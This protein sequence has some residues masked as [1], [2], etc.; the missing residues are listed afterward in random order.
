ML[1]LGIVSW[2]QPVHGYEVRRELM[3]W[4]ADQ[5]ANVQPGSVYH[6]LK[7]MA[8]EGLLEEVATERVGNRPARTSYKLTAAGEREFQDL[9]RRYWWQPESPVEPFFAALSFMPNL[10]REEII[11]ALR[12]RANLLRTHLEGLAAGKQHGMDDAPPHVFE[13]FHL[14]QARGE[15]EAAWCDGVVEQIESGRLD[16]WAWREKILKLD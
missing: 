16:P 5:W 3:S 10:P 15:A 8:E 6:A 12:H 4:N 7:K 11:A 9:L 13:M 14:W 1:I 2:S